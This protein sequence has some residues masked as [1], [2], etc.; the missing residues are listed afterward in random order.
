M[1]DAAFDLSGSNW[2][3][4]QDVLIEALERPPEVRAAFLL[5]ACGPNA[6]L[7]REAESLLDAHA[8]SGD[9]LERIDPGQIGS[10]LDIDDDAW[11]DREVGSYRIMRPLGRGGMGV[12]YLAHDSRLE[13][14]VAVKVLPAWLA[15]D[16]IARRQ[17]VTEARAAAALDHPNIGVIHEI[18][19][20]DDG[21][22]FIAMA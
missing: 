14:R 9:F 10:L 21:H 16:A 7:H 15:A 22:P 20:T 11:V 2:V 3:K 18:G 4:L 1:S 6:S 8:D 13:R 19:E 12:V 17:L 5:Q